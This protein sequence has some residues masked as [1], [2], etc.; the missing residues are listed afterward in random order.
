MKH[1]EIK[2][3]VEYAVGREDRASRAV[4]LEV[5]SECGVGTGVL[6]IQT[7]YIYP[8]VRLL[9]GSYREWGK[10][11]PPAFSEGEEGHVRPRDVICTWEEYERRK[12]A[13]EDAA[14]ARRRDEDKAAVEAKQLEG[15][16]EALGIDA[17]VRPYSRSVAISREMLG[18]L[19]DLAEHAEPRLPVNKQ[20]GE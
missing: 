5:R 19:L 16:L 8:R 17:A 14:Q 12:Q 7:T 3:G 10:T 15:R 1:S 20:E 2:Q 9:S 4:V 11:A 6:S 13:R 18:K